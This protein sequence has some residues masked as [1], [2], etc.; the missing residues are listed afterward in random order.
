AKGAGLLTFAIE[1]NGRHVRTADAATDALYAGLY[2]Y[3]KGAYAG[4]PADHLWAIAVAVYP[5]AR[6]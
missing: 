2:A 4:K 6:P 3:P 5:L 1:E